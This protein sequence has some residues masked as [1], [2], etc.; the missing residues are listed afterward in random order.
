MAIGQRTGLAIVMVVENL[1]ITPL[2][3]WLLGSGWHDGL[4]WQPLGIALLLVVLAGR[5]T[6]RA[7][8]P[9]ANFRLGGADPVSS[10]GR[11]PFRRACRLRCWR[12]WPLLHG[13]HTRDMLSS[14]V[15][16]PLFRR[17]DAAAGDRTRRKWRRSIPGCAGG[18]GLTGRGLCLLLAGRDPGGRAVEGTR[19]CGKAVHR[20]CR[21]LA[22]ISPRRVFA[23]AWLAIR[24][25]LRRRVGWSSGLR[26]H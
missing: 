24:E 17:L 3:E 7:I 9:A 18:R 15:A 11:R 26:G 5:R 19:Q 23:L 25:S 12:S 1:Q 2:M 16:D 4:L 8:R 14:F 21:G 6:G 10:M 13:G 20:H 22:R